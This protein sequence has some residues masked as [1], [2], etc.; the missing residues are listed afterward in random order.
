MRGPVAPAALLS[1]NDL[2][3]LWL[4]WCPSG[5]IRG[6]TLLELTGPVWRIRGT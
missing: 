4:R 5:G 3:V 2:L 6:P 1:Y